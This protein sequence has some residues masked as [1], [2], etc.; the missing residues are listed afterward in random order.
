MLSDDVPLFMLGFMPGMATNHFLQLGW[1]WS[2]QGV[3]CKDSHS[4]DNPLFDRKGVQVAS[5]PESCG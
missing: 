5:V 3:V 2:M 1:S 4:V